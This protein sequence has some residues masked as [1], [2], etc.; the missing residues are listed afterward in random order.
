MIRRPPR[1]TLSSSSAASDV[2]KRQ[3]SKNRAR[4][5]PCTECGDEPR[6]LAELESAA[7]DAAGKVGEMKKVMAPSWCERSG[8]GGVMYDSEIDVFRRDFAVVDSDKDGSI[9]AQEISEL[10]KRQTETTP[11]QA[12]LRAIM[13]EF[14]LDKDGTITFNEYMTTICGPGWTAD[15]P[16]S[17]DT[18]IRYMTAVD[19][20][21][22][23]MTAFKFAAS[24][25]RAYDPEDTTKNDKLVVYHCTNPIRY[26]HTRDSDFHPEVVMERYKLVAA[27]LR[28]DQLHEIDYVV[29]TKQADSAKVR[30]KVRSY[31]DEH[32]DVIFLGG[33]GA[34]REARSPMEAAGNHQEIGSTAALVTTG[35][36]AIAFLFNG[37]TEPLFEMAQT[38]YLVAVDASD[39]SHCAVEETMRWMKKGDYLQIL[40]VHEPKDLEPAKLLS[41]RYKDL[42]VE[43]KVKGACT[44]MARRNQY[45]VAQEILEAAETRD[46]EDM[47]I[48]GAHVIVCGSHGLSRKLPPRGS[49]AYWEYRLEARQA[50]KRGSVAEEVIAGA[51]KCAVMCI[52]VDSLLS[53]A[54]KAREF[55]DWYGKNQLDWGNA[56]LNQSVQ[57]IVSK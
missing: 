13:N 15:N 39:L 32:A 6:D 22:I 38:R 48:G 3:A 31:A 42:L 49:E 35:C 20:S 23:A 33:H 40:H 2:Y 56:Q 57:E 53:G 12:Q 9:S 43:S 30:E 8:H 51:T 18:P 45:S 55:S 29:E 37:Q 47:T 36:K 21:D 5:L 44:S 14:D 50:N 7:A 52:T 26:K 10:V 27:K 17:H 16:P 11:S 54:V 24:R 19:G 28:I 1:S 4:V 34:K 41:K 25:L 46:D